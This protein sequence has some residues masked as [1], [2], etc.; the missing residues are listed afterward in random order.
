MALNVCGW[1]KMATGSG[2]LAVPQNPTS[3]TGTAAVVYNW[4]ELEGYQ[5]V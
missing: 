3:W 2:H 1:K 5:S 4:F